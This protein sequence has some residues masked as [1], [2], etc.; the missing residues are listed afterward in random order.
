MNTAANTRQRILE[1]AVRI[2]DTKG[3][4][5]LTLDAVAAE[6][7]LSK[8]GVLYHYPS[9]RAL[10]EGMLR[11]VLDSFENSLQRHKASGGVTESPLVAHMA[12]TEEEEQPRTESMALAIIAAAAEDPSLLEA[13]REK[14]AELLKDITN[15]NGDGQLAQILFFALEGLR[16]FGMLRLLP[17][18]FDREGMFSR[19]VQLAQN[20]PAPGSSDSSAR[21]A[22]AH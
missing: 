22:A 3:A 5:H 9:K 4:R 10:L 20:L 2:V 6:A 13:A 11:F 16:F 15:D 8:G 18:Q 1:T 12:L 19:L 7:G 17:D 21:L 14:I